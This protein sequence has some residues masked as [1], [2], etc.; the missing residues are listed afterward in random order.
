L[1]KFHVA[2]CVKLQR[3]GAAAHGVP[4]LHSLELCVLQL[5]ARVAG[6]IPS[7]EPRPPHTCH[8]RQVLP[9]PVW[10]CHAADGAD[11][12]NASALAELTVQLIHKETCYPFFN[13]QSCCGGMMGVGE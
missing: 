9:G 1:G 4:S 6:F 11:R 10:L 2:F 3:K 5:L 12:Q 13:I 7:V 8:S